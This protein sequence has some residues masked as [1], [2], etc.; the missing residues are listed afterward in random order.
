MTA[1]THVTL[2]EYLRR[3]DEPECE[4]IAG[5]LV[6]KPMGTYEHMT[7]ERRL[8]KLLEPFERRG[9]GEVVCELTMVH[10]EE[11]RVPDV[12]FVQPGARFENGVLM[13]PPLLCVEILSPSQ[14]LSELFAKCELYHAWGVPHCWV[15]DPLGKA[16]WEYHRDSTV[17]SLADNGVLRAN[18][19]EISVADLFRP[20]A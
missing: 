3:N 16:T 10:I 15:I 18:E 5:E 1:V 14:R 13:D 12:V 6:P 4:L 19:I 9:M 17:N 2:A 11:A 20:A 7:M 8:Q